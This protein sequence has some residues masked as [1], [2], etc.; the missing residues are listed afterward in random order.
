MKLDKTVNTKRGILYGFINRIVTI[1]MPFI[2]QTILIRTLG[3]EFVGVKGLFTSILM[4]LSLTELGIGSAIVY[5]MY[6]PIAEDDTKT[7]DALLN[8][9]RSLY[10]KIGIIIFVLGII[11]TPFLNRMI[12]GEFPAQINLQ[13][14]FWLYLIN[15]VLS[16]WLFA[17]KSSIL[18]A[19]QRIDVIN[20][21]SSAI[22][23]MTNVFQILVL[24]LSKNFYLYQCVAIIFTIVNNL[25][26]SVCVSCMYPEIECKGKISNELSHNIKQNIGG[27]VIAKVCATTR[28][29]FDN[30]FISMFLGLTQAAMYTNYIY[31]FTS[32][33][34]FMGIISS[35]ILAGVGNSIALETK[36]NNYRQMLI[37]NTAYLCISGWVAICMLCLYQPFMECWV[38]KDLLFNTE[39]MLLFPIYFFIL[40]MGDIRCVYSDAAGLFW[41]NRVRNIFEAISN[42]VLNYVLVIKY[43]VFGV[44]LATI[45]TVFIFGFLTSAIVI[46]KYYYTTGFWKYIENCIFYLTMTIIMGVISMFICNNMLSVSPIFNLITRAIYCVT[47]MPLLYLGLIFWR[48]D[49]KDSFQFMKS[50]I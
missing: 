6:K 37:L 29:T 19:Y 1:I 5:N 47:L 48:K 36:E 14:V 13:V 23:V 25:I 35:S 31:I 8:L 40:K 50:H 10:R 3:A 45:I 39:T 17:Y 4:V 41:Q 24:L 18:T 22:Q 30:I 20:I 44:L 21:I 12:R 46:F 32:L 2:S 27:L 49:F 11:M 42:I 43:G 33:N 9:Y 15:T 16:Y 38:G 28:N 26:V 7:I 34:A